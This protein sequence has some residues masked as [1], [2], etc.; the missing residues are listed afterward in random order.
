[1]S[2]KVVLFLHCLRRSP[3][4]KQGQFPVGQ[5]STTFFADISIRNAGLVKKITMVQIAF[6]LKNDSCTTVSTRFGKELLFQLKFR[7]Q[8]N[9]SLVAEW[10]SIDGNGLSYQNIWCKPWTRFQAN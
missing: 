8:M 1:M 10:P 2:I 4:L 6:P 7:K 9:Q 5:W 3:Y